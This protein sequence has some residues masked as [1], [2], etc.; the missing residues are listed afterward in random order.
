VRKP[1]FDHVIA[2]A[3]VIS[4]E[5]EIVVIGSQSIW[6]SVEAPPEA[7]L[8]SLEADVYPRRDPSRA[9]EIDGMLGDGSQ[10]Q[11]TYGYYAHGVGPETAKAPTGWEERLVTVEIPRRPGEKGHVRALCLER[12]DL[13]LAKCVAGRERDWE[14]AKVALSAGIV[15]LNGLLVLVDDLPVS[16]VVRDHVRSMLKGIQKQIG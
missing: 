14:F 13:V 6:G 1:D 16:A 7:M 4:G 2:S 15:E 11:S 10:F 3:A 5:D 12:H 8:R 9:E